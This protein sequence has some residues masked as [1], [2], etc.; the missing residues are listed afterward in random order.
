MRAGGPVLV[1]IFLLSVFGAY[2]FLDRIQKLRRADAR[3]EPLLEQVTPA[4]R[5]GQFDRAVIILK[6][7]PAPAARLLEAG[8]GRARHGPEAMQAAI[9]EVTLRTEEVA[10]K[11]LTT[12]ATVAQ[13]APLLGFLGTVTGM[14]RAF[15]VLATTTQA[16]PAQLAG[17]ISEAL[18]TTAA[19]LIVAIPAYV[20][21]NYLTRRADGVVAKVERAR[22]LLVG[23]MAEREGAPVRLAANPP[24]SG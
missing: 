5:A 17:G 4:V 13:V 15:T 6:R 11:G 1:V 19:G 18:I 7:S 20:G 22:E 2:V 9:N 8:L 16:T 3:P 14:I 10:Y 21:H 24:R 12:L 23:L